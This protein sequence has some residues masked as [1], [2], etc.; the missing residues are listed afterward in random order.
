MGHLLQLSRGKGSSSE[1]FFSSS[2]TSA[3]RG[4]S[5]IAFSIFSGMSRIGVFVGELFVLAV[6][7]G[8]VESLAWRPGE[9][10]PC[11]SAFPGAKYKHAY[12]PQGPVHGE[13]LGLVFYP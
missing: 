3:S 4:I 10:S 6:N 7:F 9:S 12:E 5:L 11:P 8:V 2:I 13:E 1:S